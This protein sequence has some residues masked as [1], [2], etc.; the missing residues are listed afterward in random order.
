MCANSILENAVIML[1]SLQVT[2]TMVILPDPMKR[3]KNFACCA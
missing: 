2:K 3:N 1:L